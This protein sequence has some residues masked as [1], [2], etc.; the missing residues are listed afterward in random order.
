[1]QKKLK[2]LNDIIHFCN[3]N[4]FQLDF[5]LYFFSKKIKQFS[6]ANLKQYF[7]RYILK[8]IHFYFLIY[9]PIYLHWKVV[10]FLLIYFEQFVIILDLLLWLSRLDLQSSLLFLKFS[11]LTHLINFQTLAIFLHNLTL[12]LKLHFPFLFIAILILPHKLPF[13]LLILIS[14]CFLPTISVYEFLFLY[15]R[16]LLT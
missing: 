15:L 9:N 10:H 7:I 4:I 3:F 1:M 5:F 12:T 8:N 13:L 14:F 11:H 6:F 16:L 2:L